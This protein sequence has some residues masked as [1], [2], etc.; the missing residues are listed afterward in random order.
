MSPGAEPAPDTHPRSFSISHSQIT[1]EFHSWP[2][3]FFQRQ[4]R[5]CFLEANFCLW[6]WN[7]HFPLCSKEDQDSKDSMSAE[8][9]MK[10]VIKPKP[11]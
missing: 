11:T 5:K 2:F 8:D 1:S 4:N 9:H 6:L 10:R 3:E 7:S